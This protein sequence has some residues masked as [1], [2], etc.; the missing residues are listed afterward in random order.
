MK[1]YQ[2]KVTIKDSHPPIWRRLIVPAG[3]SF[4]QLTLVLVNAIGWDGYHL[5]D[6][7]F[8]QEGVILS[9][10]PEDA[11]DWDCDDDVVDSSEYLIDEF[12]EVGS[13]FVYTYDFGDNWEHKI[14]VEKLIPDYEYAYPMVIKYKGNTPPEDCGGIWGYYNMLNILNDPSDPEYEDIKDCFDQDEYNMD[15][16]NKL[17]SKM[18]KTRRKIKPRSEEELWADFEKGKYEMGQVEPPADRGDYDDYDDD[19]EDSFWDNEYNNFNK[20]QMEDALREEL[21][22]LLEHTALVMATSRLSKNTKMTADEIKKALEIPDKD[23]PEILE[24]SKRGEAAWNGFNA[25]NQKE[26]QPKSDSKKTKIVQ[27]DPKKKKK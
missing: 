13:S 6:Y 9:E 1:A 19:F 14:D 25:L 3:L 24:A 20:Q 17:L 23:W 7:E 27:F 26:E 8:K 15:E 4:S 18:V 10:N 21:G 2:L 5:S 16:T 11:W 12:F 22:D